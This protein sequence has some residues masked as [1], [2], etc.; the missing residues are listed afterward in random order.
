MNPSHLVAFACGLFV[1]ASA[2]AP[3]QACENAAAV[4]EV[5]PETAALAQQIAQVMVEIALQ[6]EMF[7]QDAPPMVQLNEQRSR[8][9]NRLAQLQPEG[10]QSAIARATA[11][12]I[13]VKMDDLETQIAQDQ[14]RFSDVHPSLQLQRAQLE[15]LRQRLIDLDPDRAAG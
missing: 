15:A 12:A 14:S 9:E 2:I 4:S 6:G 10:Y 8:L 7:T 1:S 5:A 3:A 11:A 13:A